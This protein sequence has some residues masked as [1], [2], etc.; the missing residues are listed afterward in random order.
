MKVAVADVKLRRI[1]LASL[2]ICDADGALHPVT[3]AAAP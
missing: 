1:Q 2:T 3:P